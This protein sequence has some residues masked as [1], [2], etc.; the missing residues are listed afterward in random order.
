MSIIK[1]VKS[2][3]AKR[4]PADRSGH[5][6]W[7]KDDI[8]KVIE[9]DRSAHLRWDEG[10]LESVPEEKKS[11]LTEAAGDT[12]SHPKEAGKELIAHQRISPVAN[13]HYAKLHKS[14]QADR[15]S[16]SLE[17]EH[18]HRY[19][20]ESSKLN[21]ALRKSKGKKKPK[22]VHY[23][24]KVTSGK[25]PEDHHVYRSFGGKIPSHMTH[26]GALIKDHGYAGTSTDY[27][28]ASSFVTKRNLIH[29]MDANNV[30]HTHK[31]IAKIHVPKG[32]KAH[33]LDN[34]AA[35]HD[36]VAERELLLHRGTTFKVTGH[37]RHIESKPS[38]G[39]KIHHHIIH[40][41]VY[42]QENHG[43]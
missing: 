29:H 3:F 33:Y 23:L 10:D 42:K 22:G 37:S 27:D 11:H 24:D 19:K 40:M 16:E 1:T 14:W 28:I 12:M 35:S 13:Q 17:H 30:S 18:I 8:E 38:R 2:I 36:A 9:P 25:T 39:E 41:K 26:K 7:K 15:W 4:K 20:E 5:L 34:S 21:N 6:A 31:Y 43:S 32:T